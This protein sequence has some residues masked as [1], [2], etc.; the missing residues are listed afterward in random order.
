MR[1]FL[2]KIRHQFE[3]FKWVFVAGVWVETKNCQ[4]FHLP[5]RHLDRLLFLFISTSVIFLLFAF[6][7]DGGHK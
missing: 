3:T 5:L 4:L 2:S 7:S 6:A 1:K